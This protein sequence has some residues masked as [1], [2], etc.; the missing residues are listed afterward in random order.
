MEN[1]V[2]FFSIALTTIWVG[3]LWSM[4][5]VTSVLFNK[6]PSA[7][8]AGVLVEDMF[9]YFNYFG[10]FTALF[11]VFFGFKKSGIRLF[12][13]SYFWIIFLMLIV[14]MINFFGIHSVLETLKIEALSKEVMESVFSERYRTRHGIASI[15]YLLECFLG[16]ILVLKVRTVN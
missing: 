7:Y 10:I 1:L 14:I 12:Q 9:L 5:M 13:K 11:L 8:L 6:I 2:K 16:I 4:L 15:A 3:S